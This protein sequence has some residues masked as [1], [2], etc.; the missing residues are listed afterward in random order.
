[1][2]ERTC[3]VKVDLYNVF[4]KGREYKVIVFPRIERAW[5]Y[6]DYFEDDQLMV[7]GSPEF[8]QQVQL[9]LAAL[10]ADPSLIVYFS[11]KHK[12]CRRYG[13]LCTYDAVFVRPEL[14]FRRSRWYLIKSK[15][16]KQNWIGT[17]T[18]HYNENKLNDLWE[19][20]YAERDWLIERKKRVEELLGDTVFLVLPESVCVDYHHSVSIGLKRYDPTDDYASYVGIG[21]ISPPD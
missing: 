11:I 13:D 19:R 7:D 8:F 16:D 15:L 6:D 2:K 21:Y 4:V 20:K 9:A 1:M 14:Q 18:I 12:D 17:Y 3:K 10:I 5:G